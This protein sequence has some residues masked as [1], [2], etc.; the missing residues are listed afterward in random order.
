MRQG[1]DTFVSSFSATA[2][3]EEDFVSHNSP[4]DTSF[5][6]L[7][8]RVSGKNFYGCALRSAKSDSENSPDIN[9]FLIQCGP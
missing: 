6:L 5:G 9:Y 3:G 1:E 8:V 2:E 7:R 4:F